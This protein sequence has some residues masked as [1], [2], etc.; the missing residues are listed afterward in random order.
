MTFIR[1]VRPAAVCNHVSWDLNPVA[2]DWPH[3]SPRPRIIS[4]MHSRGAMHNVRPEHA[5]M[6]VIFSHYLEDTQLEA[7]FS[8]GNCTNVLQMPN[9]TDESAFVK[10]PL[11]GPLRDG[12]FVIGNISNGAAWKHSQDFLDICEGIA[13]PDVKFEFLGA[14]DL[15]EKARPKRR[16]D[17]LPAFSLSV[18]DYLSGISVLIHK[19]Q[20]DIAETWCRTVTEAMF[21]GVPVV[22]EKIGGIREQI[23]HGKTGFLCNTADDFTDYIEALYYKE[24]LYREI[25]RNAR[26]HAVAN[27]GLEVCRRNL[28]H[29]LTEL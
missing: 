19:T 4:F 9:C 1:R 27:F 29:L 3:V 22:A 7:C 21:A 17:I 16:I 24:D 10:L 26:E 2:K 15:Q 5:D 12:E 23:V 8:P 14:V 11:L 28:L 20:S 25:S 18:P 6:S 13:I